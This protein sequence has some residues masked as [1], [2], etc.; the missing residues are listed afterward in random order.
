[1]KDVAIL[2]KY[3]KNYNYGGMLQGYALHKVIEDMGLSCDVISYNVNDNINPIY[4]GVLQQCMQYTLSEI[5]SKGFEKLVGKFDFGI[6]DILLKRNRLFEEFMTRTNAN[7]E[8]YNDSNLKALN[9]E[10]RFFVSGSDQVWNPNAVRRLYLQQFVSEEKTKVSYAASIGRSNFSTLEADVLIPAIKHFDYLGVREKTAKELLEKYGVK[11]VE[12]TLDP[13]MLLSADDWEEVAAP[14]QINSHYALFYFFSD[15]LKIRNGLKSFCD[16]MNLIP[17]FIPYAK[18]EFNVGDGKGVGV[19]LKNVGPAEFLS[20]VKYAD[21]VFTDSFHGTVFSIICEKQFFVFERNK[22]GHVSMNSRLYDLLDL[23]GL[24]E[25]LIQFN[26]IKEIK[27]FRK[28]D[29][30]KVEGRLKE[31]KDSSMAF[32]YKSLG[33]RN[34]D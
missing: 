12:I 20:A 29:Y 28:I 32:L 19:R 3:Y 10:Y 2:T 34:N 14:R 15:S 26:G 18:Q 16:E 31:L 30:V 1:M 6:K 8:I 24:S 13:T 21:Y 17:V 9:E 4:T 23:F 11:N 25:R 33:V 27:Q 7:T 5:L 22:S